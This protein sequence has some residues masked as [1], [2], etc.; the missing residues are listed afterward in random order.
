MV[1]LT[2]MKWK[3]TVSQVAKTS[4]PRRLA[5]A[6]IA[7]AMSIHGSPRTGHA[8]RSGRVNPIPLAAYRF[9]RLA[10]DLGSQPA[11]VDVDDVGA[12]VKA[13]A[14]DGG[15]DPVFAERLAGAGHELAQQ[16]E[17]ALGE[18]HSAEVA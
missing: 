11:Y 14:P 5:I 8:Q 9:D 7:Q 12:W 15:E 6:K 4:M 17:L 3:G 18:L 13:V 10:A 16:E 1:R 2:Q